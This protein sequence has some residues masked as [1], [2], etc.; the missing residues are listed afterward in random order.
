[1]H[2]VT[3][4]VDSV[5][6][7]TKRLGEGGFGGMGYFPGDTELPAQ[8]FIHPSSASGALVQLVERGF[9][10]PHVAIDLDEVLAG[11]GIGGTGQPS[12]PPTYTLE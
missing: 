3:F 12:P 1:L 4:L 7:A 6:E 10:A 9:G 11:R 5:D 2:H 8:V